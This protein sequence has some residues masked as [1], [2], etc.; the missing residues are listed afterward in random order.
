MSTDKWKFIV[1]LQFLFILC[2]NIEFCYSKWTQF[3][4][5]CQGGSI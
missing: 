2:T 4:N 3:Q 5:K 1:S